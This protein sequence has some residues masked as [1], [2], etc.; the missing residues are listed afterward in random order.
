MIKKMLNVPIPAIADNFYP[1]HE[2][3]SIKDTITS[4]ESNY[5]NHITTASYLT[6]LPKQLISSIIYIES[7]GQNQPENSAGAVGLMEVTAPTVY[8]AI[9]LMNYNGKLT[10]II[11]GYLDQYLPFADY[12]MRGNQFT[13]WSSGTAVPQIKQYLTNEGFNIFCGSL[14]FRNCFEKSIENGKA[15]LDKAICFYNYGLYH[16]FYRTGEFINSTIHNLFN[17][18]NLP[19]E[20]Q[21][22]I[23]KMIGKNGTLDSILN[24]S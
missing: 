4:I 10:A 14:V 5:G 13:M 19:K 18:Q 6:F 17:N 12:S 20:T 21:D 16:A 23:L 1:A 24:Y 8:D 7:G 11:K 22:Y 3:P 9:R 2:I 15:R